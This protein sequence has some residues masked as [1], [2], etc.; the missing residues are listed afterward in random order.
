MAENPVDLLKA[1]LKRE[2]KRFCRRHDA[3]WEAVSDTV[4]AIQQQHWRAVFFGG[5]LRS[6]LI[7]RLVH[8]REGCPRD[9]D[10]VIQ[11]ARL[12][13]LREQ[14]RQLVARETRFGGLQLRR[15]NWLFDVW[16]LEQT[17]GLVNDRVSQPDFAHLPQ[18]TFLNVEAAAIDVWPA[19]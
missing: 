7:S 15:D 13:M 16:P 8:R 11:G 9:V 4:T 1:L 10:I 3:L 12:E 17:W 5:T 18:T 19:A 6:L 2:V 14:F